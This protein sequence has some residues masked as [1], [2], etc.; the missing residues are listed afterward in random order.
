M[1]R[2]VGKLGLLEECGVG[3][4]RKIRALKVET[5]RARRWW[6]VNVRRTFLVRMRRKGEVVGTVAVTGCGEGDRCRGSGTERG[7]IVE[8]DLEVVRTIGVSCNSSVSISSVA[9]RAYS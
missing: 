8:S 5:W 3:R 6:L 2:S 9:K 4:R 7:Y 1:N